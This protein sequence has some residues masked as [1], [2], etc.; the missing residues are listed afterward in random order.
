MY[1]CWASRRRRGEG[2]GFGMLVSLLQPRKPP[3]LIPEPSGPTYMLLLPIGQCDRLHHLTCWNPAREGEDL[4]PAARLADQLR[5]HSILQT[6]TVDVL[7]TCLDGV[8]LSGGGRGRWCDGHCERVVW[9]APARGDTI[10]LS[11]ITL[12][13][14]RR[15]E[16]WEVMRG[17]LEG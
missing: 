13:R 17:E 10:P 7:C 3:L 15:G 14:G 9:P 1:C 2:V 11:N 5:T 4:E 16:G 12:S 6:V 8:W